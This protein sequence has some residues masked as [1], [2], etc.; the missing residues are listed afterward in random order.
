MRRRE[1]LAASA[2]ALAASSVGLAADTSAATSGKKGCAFVT[3]EGSPWLNNI[4]QLKANWLYSWGSERPETLPASVEFAPM[5]W[6]A[7][8]VKNLEERVD[9][10]RPLVKS[11]QIKSLM[12]FNEPDQHK[13]SNMSVEKVVKFWPIL[14][15][16]GVPLVSPGCVHPDREWMRQFMEQVEQKNLRV[17]FVAVHSYGGPSA[18]ALVKRLE[19]VHSEFGRRLWM[20]EF[21]VGDWEAKTAADNRHS[22]QRVAAFMREALPALDKLKCLDRYA[23]FAAEPSSA[24]LGTSAL[25]KVD[26]SLTPLGRIYAAHDANPKPI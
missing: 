4:R 21:A 14:M 5:I 6:N 24:P 16:L 7:W 2:A 20:T 12:G 17:D 1:F 19:Q 9:T 22:P 10:L 13:Q 8:S 26:G 23:W 25:V 3:K 18:E 15:E 11:G